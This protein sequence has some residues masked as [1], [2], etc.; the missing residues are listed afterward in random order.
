MTSSAQA[1]PLHR[2]ALG[3]A[4]PWIQS[5]AFDLAFFILSPLV[6]LPLVVGILAGFTRLNYVGFLLAFAHYLST[7]VF[8]FWDENRAEH[9][10]RWLAFFAGPLIITVVFWSIVAFEVPLLI[11]FVLFF[12]NTVH[13]AFQ[14]CG[15]LSIYRHRAGVFDPRQKPLANHAIIAVSVW[16]ALWNIETHKEVWPILAWVAP[17]FPQ[18]VRAGAALVALL[19]VARLA[20]GLWRRSREGLA[21]GPLEIGIL[22]T[23]LLLFHP[24]LWMRDSEGATFVMLLPH[25]LQYLGLV[26]LL[27]RRKF[28]K[29]EGSA[30]QR[31]LTVVS[32][33][34]VLLA[35][36]L[37]AGGMAF[38]AGKVLFRSIGHVEQFEAIY[39]LLAFVH[40][41]LDS[42]FWAFRDPHVRRT[43]GPYLAAAPTRRTSVAG[44][45]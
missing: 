34:N 17:S 7:F 12:W 22:L 36:V 45:G 5:P 40:F 26:W 28:T 27:N 20:L 35:G 29:P 16:L 18:I 3:P 25:Y 44:A 41:Y 13:V 10:A 32:H 9:R 1:L 8:F 43:V 21:P 24:Y 30:A 19:C 37:L 15:I 42:L 33:N 11:P 2:P 23:G 39:L 6:T 4:G 14:S 31:W 38:L